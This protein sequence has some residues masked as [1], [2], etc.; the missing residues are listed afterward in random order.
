M[1]QTKSI[2]GWI[3]AGLAIALLTAG[4]AVGQSP[5]V[6]SRYAIAQQSDFN[7]PAYY[8]I[9][10]TV[11]PDHYRPVADW[12]GRLILP[13][14][15]EVDDQ[16]WVWVEVL[17]SPDPQWLGQT[18][19]LTWQESDARRIYLQTVTRGIA[20]TA[21][22]HESIAQGNVHPERLDGWPQVGPLQSLAGAHPQDDVMVALQGVAVQ[23]T[24]TGPVL[25]VAEEPIQVTGRYYGVVQFLG[26]VES[27]ERPPRCPRGSPCPSEQMRVRHYNPATQQF[28]GP[29]ETVRLPQV[30]PGYGIFQSTPD[31]IQRSPAGQEGWYIYGAQNV[32]GQFVVQAIAPRALVQYR[33][34]RLTP[35]QTWVGRDRPYNYVNVGN[36]RRTPQRK[37]T[38]QT[39]WLHGSQSAPDWQEGDRLLV[40]HLFGGIGGERGEPPA[41]AGTVTG[42]FAYGLATLVHDELTQDLR[43]DITYAQVYS[44]NPNGIIAGAIA[45]P[46]YMGDLQVGWLGTRPVSDVLIKLDAV[47]DDYQFG[48]DRL[49]VMDELL[50]QLDIMMAR[51]R[52]GDGT[53]AAI[54]TPAQ[55]CV[56]DANQ[57]LYKT[58]QAI[59]RRVAQTPTLQ[60]W[61]H[62]HPT[63]PQTLRFKQLVALGDRLQRE[64]VPVGIVRPDWQHN[65]HAIA[66]A[67]PAFERRNDLITQLLSWRTIMPRVAYD[68]VLTA[69]LEQGAGVWVLRT[70]QVGGW[71]PT[72]APLAPTELFGRYWGVPTFFSRLIE[73]LRWPTRADLTV[74]L[75]GLGIYGAI[76]WPLARVLGVVTRPS[77]TGSRLSWAS[78]ARVVATTL[79]APVLLEE[80]LF[81]VALV[82]HP[83]EA[84]QPAT[85]ALWGLLSLSLFVLYHPV[86]GW[87]WYRQGRATL[88]SPSFL[89]LVAEL[90]LVCTIVY[91]ITGSL[92]AIALIHWVVVVVWLLLLG[93]YQRLNG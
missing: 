74:A 21:E 16:D 22:T 33:P 13:D 52:T 62:D 75:L 79:V 57:A 60:T 84:V 69:L 10:Q 46:R 47:T 90:G 2:W 44:H 64:L 55:S 28:D 63:D 35:A 4:V 25:A 67:T 83:Q 19:R 92:W 76:A 9:Q 36:W 82:P 81:R 72:L 6:L 73:S 51:Y 32:A 43:V 40:I 77:W 38:I 93:G 56:Q 11:D 88:C 24:A 8:P 78:R 29:A 48:P 71:D 91:V 31:Q 41:V 53:G 15:T 65:D 59:T 14:P 20:F 37:G 1:G 30:L 80:L 23:S 42:H 68:Q 12:L 5:Q 86:N 39:A 7:Q 17:H 18:L 26:P 61:L 58:I 34:D 66:G 89:L 85:L 50:H 54:V 45:W 27:A 70:N 3:V 87:L 49:S